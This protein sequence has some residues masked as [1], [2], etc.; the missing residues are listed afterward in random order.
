MRIALEG[1]RLI[2]DKFDWNL[3]RTFLVIASEGSINRAAARL[4]VT[5]PAVSQALKRLED[6]LGEKLL[7]RTGRAFS[8]TEAGR[9]LCLLGNDMNVTAS[10]IIYGKN[11]D[12]VI[13]GTIRLGIISRI[14]SSSYD[15][16][17][18]DFHAS[19]PAVDFQ[20]DV[21]RSADIV[22]NLKQKGLTAGICLM[23]ACSSKFDALPFSQHRYSFFC[24]KSHRFYGRADI[25]VEEICKEDF[26]TFSSDQ[27][28]GSLSQLAIFRERHGFSGR[29][30]AVS[31]NLDELIRL[32]RQGFG[33]GCFP[34]HIVA[35]S[36]YAQSLWKLPPEDGVAEVDVYFCSN[37]EQY[38]CP[39]E[40]IFIE[41]MKTFLEEEQR[42][43]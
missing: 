33:I 38:H 43:T 7:N 24:G 23:P 29:I 41:S 10:Q 35:N 18:S 39:A 15:S 37:R 31:P 5:Q 19:Y 28:G 27:A 40:R 2:N 20:I 26:V 30:S 14:E 42:H 21:M 12:D 36:S 32:V 9:R 13:E 34:Q 3:I 17:M 6:Q 25:R 8:L 1:D 22:A 4:H 16:F 11:S